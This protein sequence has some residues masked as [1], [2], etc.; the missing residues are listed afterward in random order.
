LYLK[1]ESGMKGGRRDHRGSR[2]GG[3]CIWKRSERRGKGERK[4]EREREM[5]RKEREDSQVDIVAQFTSFG[6]STKNNKIGRIFPGDSD[7]RT[8]TWNKTQR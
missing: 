2:G 6:S 5:E 3:E 8:G 7:F 1:D 4:S